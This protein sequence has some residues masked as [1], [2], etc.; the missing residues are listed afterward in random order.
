MKKTLKEIASLVSGE[1][2]GSAKVV[3]NN[4]ANLEDAQAG[5][6]TFAVDDKA[7]DL[8]E[9]SKASAA[10]VPRS[11]NRFP[12]KPHV[13]V[14]DLRLAM[15]KLLGLFEQKKTPSSGTHKSA[16]ISKTAKIGSG[17]SIMSGVFIG[18]NASVGDKTVIYPGCYIG[19]N[20]RIGR[21]TT[22]HPNVVLY[23]RTVVGNRCILHSG[24]VLGVD[25]FG[26]APVDGRYEKIPQIGNVVVE[27]D[28]EIFA[29]SCVSRATMGST[30]I[31]RGTK[32]DNLT[33][34]AHNCKI[35]ED[36]AI[37]ALVAVAGSSELKNHV[38]IGGTSGVVDHVV[39]GENTVVM[40]RSGVTKDIPA[41]SVVSGFPAQDHQKE[42]EQ[43]AAIRRLPK[44]IEKLSETE[45]PPKK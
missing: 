32:I 14:H 34:I 41:N 2:S 31:K 23:D 21:E 11:L 12:S 4:A 28:V 1:L 42:L 45:K 18:D 35:G 17:C 20:C 30:M 13:K 10:I 9:R 37:T 3:I 5:D 33:H 16:V 38:S 44:I 36:C 27:D 29:N 6:I 7:M 15:A 19:D 22:L 39:I 26:F 40:G 8:L 24:A 43:Q 25:G